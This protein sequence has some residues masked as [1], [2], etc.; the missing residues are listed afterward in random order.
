MDIEWN[1][2]NGDVFWKNNKRVS[3]VL[4]V[5]ESREG[6]GLMGLFFDSRIVLLVACRFVWW[7]SSIHQPVRSQW[8]LQNFK[9]QVGKAITPVAWIKLLETVE[10]KLAVFPVLVSAV[11]MGWGVGGIV[12][13]AEFEHLLLD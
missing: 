4:W 3:I 5:T 9:L 7:R 8:K 2:W 10:T 6:F 13:L 12:A 1:G 11:L